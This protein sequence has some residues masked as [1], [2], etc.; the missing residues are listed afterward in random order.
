MVFQ[1]CQGSKP[2]C[3]LLPEPH[4]HSYTWHPSLCFGKVCNQINSFQPIIVLY[5]VSKLEK[6]KGGSPSFDSLNR[7]MEILSKDPGYK[8]LHGS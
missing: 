1:K 3:E 5:F 6:E 2:E 8:L 4:T 7:K